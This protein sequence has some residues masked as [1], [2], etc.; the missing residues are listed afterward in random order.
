MY[1]AAVT[2]FV[3]QNVDWEHDTV[4]VMLVT[5]DYVPSQASDSDVRDVGSAEVEASGS[6]RKGGQVL[7]GRS[8]V[9]G[10][11]GSTRL[12]GGSVNWTGFSGRFRYAVVYVHRGSGDDL[13]VSYTDLGSQEASNARVSLEFDRD[14]G[15]AEWTAV[16][17]G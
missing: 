11:L 10:P 9:S 1:D 12:M 6:Y 5:D 17:G 15:V 7:M 13:L 8:V 4:K 14:G 3:R 16:S 2:E